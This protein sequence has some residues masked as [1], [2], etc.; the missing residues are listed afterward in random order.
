[1]M[2]T[3]N[4]LYLQLETLLNTHHLSTTKISVTRLQAW[5]IENSRSLYAYEKTWMRQLIDFIEVT[6]PMIDTLKFLR[7]SKEK[8]RQSNNRQAQFYLKCFESMGCDYRELSGR[9]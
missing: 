5:I 6:E 1:M 7:F 4:H 3:P 2:T 9:I 8:R